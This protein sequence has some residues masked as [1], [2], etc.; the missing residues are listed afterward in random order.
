[1]NMYESIKNNLKESSDEDALRKVAED[2]Y[3]YTTDISITEDEWF[4]GLEA[5]HPELKEVSYE[6]IRDFAINEILNDLKNNPKAIQKQMRID[7]CEFGYDSPEHEEIVEMY[8]ELKNAGINIDLKG[9]V[10]DENGEPLK[11]DENF[12]KAFADLLRPLV[13]GYDEGVNRIVIKGTDGTVIKNNLGVK[14]LSRVGAE[15][16]TYYD[17]DMQLHYIDMSY[18]DTLDLYNGRKLV[19]SINKDEYFKESVSLVKETDNEYPVDIDDLADNLFEET[20]NK[21]MFDPDSGNNE[22]PSYEEYKDTYYYDLKK[23]YYNKAVKMVRQALVNLKN[24]WYSGEGTDRSMLELNDNHTVWELANENLEG[25]DYTAE[26]WSEIVERKLDDFKKETGVDV[27]C[28]GRM[29]R[30]V[31][32]PLTLE[33]CLNFYKLQEVQERL[34]QEAIDEFNNYELSDEEKKPIEVDYTNVVSGTAYGKDWYNNEGTIQMKDYKVDEVTP[35]AIC[36]GANDGGFGLKE[37]TGVDAYVN[38]EEY[39]YHGEEFKKYRGEE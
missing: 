35:E 37:L 31:C 2:F 24:N 36:K 38:G 20:I 9:Y 18:V 12:A 1:M 29:G 3:E 7:C 21:Y 22:I 28:Y 27:G 32:V 17:T 13:V 23:S 34:E 11:E 30:H 26:L 33:N 5:D 6:E 8:K 19:A 4:S 25:Y 15:D 16:F 10:F 14:G 39:K